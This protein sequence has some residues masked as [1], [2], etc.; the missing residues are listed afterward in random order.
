MIEYS[1]TAMAPMMPVETSETSARE[2]PSRTTAVVAAKRQMLRIQSSVVTPQET[3]PV[4]TPGT[5]SQHI[6]LPPELHQ[7]APRAPPPVC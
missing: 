5:Q 4:H 1:I 6:P 2:T 3:A 7:L